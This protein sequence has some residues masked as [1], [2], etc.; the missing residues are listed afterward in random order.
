MTVGAVLSL[1]F[2]VTLSERGLP[3]RSVRPGPLMVIVSA[4]LGCP[5]TSTPRSTGE[6]AA[7]YDLSGSNYSLMDGSSTFRARDA[8]V[9]LEQE[10]KS[11]NAGSVAQAKRNDD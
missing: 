5:V 10:S 6:D 2:R 9:G 4:P 8:S 3:T 7:T 11:R 1:R